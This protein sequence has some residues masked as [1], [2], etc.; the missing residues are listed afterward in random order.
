MHRQI[1]NGGIMG[2][3]KEKIATDV[4]ADFVSNTRYAVCPEC[5]QELRFERPI[6]AN[7][8][9]EDYVH[10]IKC[11]NCGVTIGVDLFE[12]EK[13]VVMKTGR[14]RNF[15]MMLFSLLFVLVSVFTYLSSAGI[16]SFIPTDIM[17]YFDSL[18][19]FNGI[20]IW[21][22]VI[23]QTD[24]IAGVF[25]LDIVYGILTVVLP[26]I[27]FTI[28]AINLI[29]GLGCFIGK[30]YSRVYNLIASTLIGG[31]AVTLLFA[32]FIVL[33]ADASLLLDYF[34]GLISGEA[35]ALIAVA[36]LGLIM[37]LLSLVYLKSMKEKR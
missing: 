34:K 19:V 1:D 37:F 6:N 28:S 15:F 21:E 9:P 2:K 17:V 32:P 24:V 11:P 36:G 31:S 35:Y 14:S 4:S 7:E 8:L 20:G 29:V 3:K 10:P 25:E 5:K 30:K 22:G 18:S 26:L 16:L 27:F 33:G 12:G 13:P 23:T